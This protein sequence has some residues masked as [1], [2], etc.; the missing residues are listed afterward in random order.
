MKKKFEAV[1]NSFVEEANTQ[2]E[3]VKEAWLELIQDKLKNEA[4]AVSIME[5]EIK[6]VEDEES[7]RALLQQYCFLSNTL[8]LK[9]IADKLDLTE[10]KER[11]DELDDE[12]EGFYTSLLAE[13][14]VE[15]ED[16]KKI[17]NHKEVYLSLKHTKSYTLL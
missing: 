7:L 5:N 4:K 12:R 11:I 16:H 17:D 15:I 3:K 13:D 14:F 2:L 8:L 1:F 9:H 6:R 10:S